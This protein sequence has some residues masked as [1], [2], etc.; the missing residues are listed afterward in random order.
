MT[1]C[2]KSRA[3]NKRSVSN[4]NVR[5]HMEP[6]TLIG[7]LFTVVLVVERLWKYTLVHV[8]RSKCCGSEVEFDK[9]TSDDV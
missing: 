1:P 9:G 4:K 5:D 8:K 6:V 3:T 2:S 7:L